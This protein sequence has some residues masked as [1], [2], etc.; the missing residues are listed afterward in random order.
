MKSSSYYS[1]KLLLCFV[2][3]SFFGYASSI[4]EI[5]MNLK[6]AALNYQNEEDLPLIPNG[7]YKKGDKVEEVKLIKQKLV[8]EGLWYNEVDDIF[9][10]ALEK[11]IMLFQERYSL[12]SDGIIGYQTLVA[13]NLSNKNKLNLI[14]DSINTLMNI[15]NGDFF[16]L[17]SVPLFKLEVFKKN[18]KIMTQKIIVGMHSRKTP[19]MTSN[20]THIVFFPTWSMPISIFEKDKKKHIVE[21]PGYIKSNDC[22]VRDEYGER[23]DPHDINW[24]YISKDYYPYSIIQNPGINN[25]LGVIK[26]HMDNNQAIYLHSSPKKKQNLFEKTNRALSSGCIRV[27]DPK[28]LLKLLLNKGDEYIDNNL[29]EIKTKYIELKK[30]IPVI[31]TD[32]CVEADQGDVQFGDLALIDPKKNVLSN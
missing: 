4:T 32:I 15:N 23:V 22:Y 2:F 31:I 5:V 11:S 14:E 19:F 1:M 17:I 3:C 18:K 10:E 28:S 24:S 9:D 26:F 16:I 6:E 8:E 7:L 20:I 13:L 25:A 27:E 30:R 29:K 21:N 12:N